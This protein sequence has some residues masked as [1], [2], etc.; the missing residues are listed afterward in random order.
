[1]SSADNPFN[2]FGWQNDSNGGGYLTGA[3]DS[4]N[5]LNV[6]VANQP[7][8]NDTTMLQGGNPQNATFAVWNVPFLA[9]PNDDFGVVPAADDGCVGLYGRTSG[10]TFSTGVCGQADVGGCGVYGISCGVAGEQDVFPISSDPSPGFPGPPDPV[11]PPPGS[12]ALGIG[13]CG[14]ALTSEGIGDEPSLD[15]L[16]PFSIGVLGHSHAGVGI[17]AHGGFPLATQSI[18]EIGLTS[19]NCAARSGAGPGA[20]LSAGRLTLVDAGDAVWENTIHPGGP[21]QTMSVDFLPQLR[22]IPTLFLT[23]Y[24]ADDRMEHVRGLPTVGSLGDIFVVAGPIR[25]RG[26]E[27]SEQLELGVFMCVQAG[28]GTAEIPTVWKKFLLGDVI[29]VANPQQI[30]IP[31]P[32]PK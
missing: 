23:S 13:V 2:F 7:N 6:G 15:T 10:T 8:S 1:V 29:E 18:A 25:A 5:S 20:I 4:G 17:R 26:N 28:Q 30:C 19:S 3:T 11:A 12:S 14:R 22:L 24:Q 32:Q 27:G 9:V 31:A 21:S 16:F